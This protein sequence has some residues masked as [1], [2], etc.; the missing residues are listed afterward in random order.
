MEFFRKLDLEFSAAELT[1]RLT[2]DTLPQHCDAI[3]KVLESHGDE[4]EIYCLWGQF[5]VRRE[6]IKGGIRFTLPTCPNALQWTL[7][8]QDDTPGVVIHLT[9]NR[10]EHDFDFIDSI[11]MFLDAWVE[12]L[13]RW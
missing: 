4:G 2:I 7:T 6:A 12:G 13:Q 5:R 11:H 9:I 10:S 8:Q 3:D 1:E